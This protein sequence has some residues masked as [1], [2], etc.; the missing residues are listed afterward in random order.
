[1]RV[2]NG[3]LFTFVFRAGHT[4]EQ[5]LSCISWTVYHWCIMTPS[6]IGPSCE[7][8]LIVLVSCWLSK[9]TIRSSKSFCRA[10]ILKQSWCSLLKTWQMRLV[11]KVDAFVWFIERWTTFCD[12]SYNCHNTGSVFIW[13]AKL[14][15][16]CEPLWSKTACSFFF[17]FKGGREL[18]T[19]LQ[20]TH[21]AQ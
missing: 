14:F 15:V 17:L 13:N 8:F 19:L 1:M 18:A 2:T 10:G 4:E 9:F 3:D 6:L 11:L 16:F 20:L 5:F 21:Q 12:A 7:W